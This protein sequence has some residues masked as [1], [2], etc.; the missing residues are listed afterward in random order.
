M[1]HCQDSVLP[2]QRRYGDT[3]PPQALRRLFFFTLALLTPSPNAPC[4][5]LCVNTEV[6]GENDVLDLKVDKVQGTY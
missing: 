5:T 4:I 2:I 1:S 3:V 6:Q